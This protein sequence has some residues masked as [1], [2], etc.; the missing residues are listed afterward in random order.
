MEV[1]CEDNHFVV[2]LFRFWLGF[3]ADYRLVDDPV[4]F[5]QVHAFVCVAKGFN[6]ALSQCSFM[7]M[8]LDLLTIRKWV[9]R[10]VRLAQLQSQPW[11][12]HR[13]QCAMMGCAHQTGVMVPFQFGRGIRHS[14]V[15]N[16][17]GS[18]SS[19][20]DV[21]YSS[22]QRTVEDWLRGHPRTLVVCSTECLRHVDASVG[23]LRR[24]GLFMRIVR[25]THECSAFLQRRLH[26]LARQI[27]Q[28]GGSPESAAVVHRSS[29]DALINEMDV[30]IVDA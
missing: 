23:V 6:R 14:A 30:K 28:L 5:D 22:M 3:F 18:V 10:R 26:A 29:F 13:R 15:A 2:G 25:G 1:I 17:R 9:G 4:L 24:A 8:F 21:S 27:D 19:V 12:A 11:D 7:P 20:Y 16:Y